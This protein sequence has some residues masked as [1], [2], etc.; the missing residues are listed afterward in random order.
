MS[1]ID[2][3][4]L[5]LKNGFISETTFPTEFM[6]VPIIKETIIQYNWLVRPSLRQGW[7]NLKRY[8]NYSN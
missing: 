4:L 6:Y 2:S 3:I 5:Q 7:V 1:S 8:R